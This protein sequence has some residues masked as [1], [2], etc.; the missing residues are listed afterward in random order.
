M[1]L[2]RSLFLG[3]AGLTSA[4]HHMPMHLS[5][6]GSSYC[7]SGAAYHSFRKRELWKS[8]MPLKCAIGYVQ[9][10]PIRL[11]FLRGSARTPTW[12]GTEVDIS[13]L[14]LWE[15]VGL[16]QCLCQLGRAVPCWSTCGPIRIWYREAGELR[17]FIPWREA[18]YHPVH[19]CRSA[20]NWGMDWWHMGW[21]FSKIQS[22]SFQR[23]KFAW[24]SPNVVTK[25]DFLQL[26]GSK[27][28]KAQLNATPYPQPFHMP[29]RLP[30][31]SSWDLVSEEFHNSFTATALLPG[32]SW[33]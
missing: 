23:P 16:V 5:R 26:L 12:G 11:A 32:W 14:D 30:P 4:T 8:L 15:G 13:W 2:F 33:S 22:N 1:L 20:P 27:I 7:L 25:S 24:K 21:P 9:P 3:A 28:S 19:S 31:K 6:T 17:I 18:L 10:R 29:C